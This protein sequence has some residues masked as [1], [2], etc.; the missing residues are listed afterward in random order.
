MQTPRSHVQLGKASPTEKGEGYG[1]GN[2]GDFNLAHRRRQ[3]RG[4]EWKGGCEGASKQAGVGHRGAPAEIGHHSTQN[5]G[6]QEPGAEG[7]GKGSSKESQ[8]PD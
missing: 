5:Q 8:D 3:S 2:Q 1:G 7:Y 6:H 4:R